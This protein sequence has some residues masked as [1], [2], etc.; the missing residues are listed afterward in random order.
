MYL[1]EEIVAILI[2][3]DNTEIHIHSSTNIYL[4]FWMLDIRIYCLAGV[5]LGIWDIPMNR[6]CKTSILALLF[7]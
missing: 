1:E 2:G 7:F 5:A 3:R 6:I 4:G